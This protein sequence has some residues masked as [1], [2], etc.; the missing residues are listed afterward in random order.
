MNDS[1][2]KP[3]SPHQTDEI[4]IKLESTTLVEPPTTETPSKLLSEMFDQDQFAMVSAKFQVL[5]HFFKQIT[6]EYKFGDFVRDILLT[7]M[8]SVKSEAGAIFEL[9]YRINQLFFRAAVG[10]SSDSV[11]KFTV[12]IGHGI[13]GY[14]AESKHPLIVN[15]LEENKIH[16]KAISKSVG[17]EARNIVAI[18]IIIRG[19]LYGVLELLN[20]VGEDGFTAGDLELLTYYCDIAAKAIEIRLMIAWS[21]KNGSGNGGGQKPEAA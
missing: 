10:Q 3:V 8:K 12:P 4:E 21:A 14:V 13:V 5:D 2:K 20:R 7:V 19:K 11:L 9:D 6:R 1:K 18:P 16:L 17:F 15:D